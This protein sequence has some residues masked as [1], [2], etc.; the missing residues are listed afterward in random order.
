LIE[1]GA[2][3]CAFDLRAKNASRSCMRILRG[4]VLEFLAERQ[5]AAT[6]AKKH[7]TRK[8]LDSG[9]ARFR[10]TGSRQ[11]LRTNEQFSRPQ[12]VGVSSGG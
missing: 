10:F 8:N 7:S 4:A 6:T 5:I 1:T 9:M 2:I 11:N 3:G 12:K